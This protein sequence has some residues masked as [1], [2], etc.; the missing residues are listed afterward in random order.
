M[1]V[2]LTLMSAGALTIGVVPGPGGAS[3][4]T[5]SQVRVCLAEYT[6]KPFPGE[7]FTEVRF[8]CRLFREMVVQE[9]TFT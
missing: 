3:C 1:A 2:D 6:Y 5:D 8:D 7:W 9:A 4:H